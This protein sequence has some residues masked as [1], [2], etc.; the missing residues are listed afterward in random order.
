M[1]APAEPAR[2]AAADRAPVPVSIGHVAVLTPDL[3]RFRAFYEDVIGLRTAVVLRMTEPPG[4]RHALLSVTDTSLL[5]A[6]EV[7]GYDPVAEGLDHGLGRRGRLDHLA[8]HVADA[9]DL[10]AVRD[11]LVA[12]GA[13]DGTVTS[14][15]TLLSVFF[16]DPDGLEA[17]VTTANPDWDPSRDTHDELLEEPDPTLYARLVAA[18]V[19]GK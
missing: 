6:V 2:Q 15:G 18:T 14:H 9:D 5:H 12:V 11:R 4:Y 1:T 10:A 8:F 16:R 19:A 7:P 13:S 17:E 3:D